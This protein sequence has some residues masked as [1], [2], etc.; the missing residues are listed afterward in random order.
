MAGGGSVV[1]AA[2]CVCVF[3]FLRVRRP[4]R[5]AQGSSSAA[6][7]VYKRQRR[8]GRWKA[9][10]P[11]RS[12]PTTHRLRPSCRK[13]DSRFVS[14]WPNSDPF[15]ESGG[16]NIYAAFANN[17]L[18][19]FDWLG[20][21]KVLIFVGDPTSPEGGEVPFTAAASAKKAELDG[22]GDDVLLMNVRS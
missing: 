7:D 19:F 1:A 21:D 9:R 5:S 16:E 11:R 14:D 8:S 2:V 18:S 22:K 12:T 17:P 20:L 3:F 4:P 15:G 6:S 10:Q 13:S